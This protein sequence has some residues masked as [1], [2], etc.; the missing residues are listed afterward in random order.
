MTA[1]NIG[2]IGGPR[3]IRCE[4]CG[5]MDANEHDVARCTHGA[6]DQLGSGANGQAVAPMKQ[7]GPS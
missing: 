7:M 2:I 5:L 4:H 1:L 3:W 6:A